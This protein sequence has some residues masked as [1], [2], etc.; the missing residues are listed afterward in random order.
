VAAAIAEAE[1]LH[2]SLAARGA[3]ER[4][5]R[6]RS[7]LGPDFGEIPPA[8]PPPGLSTIRALAN[9]LAGLATAVDGADAEPTPDAV[10]AVPNVEPAVQATLAAWERLKAEQP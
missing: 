8:G 7:L 9:S 10:A 3:A 4:D 2:A 1:K 5:G 6:V